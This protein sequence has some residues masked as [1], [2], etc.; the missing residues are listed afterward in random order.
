MY[1][2]RILIVTLFF[3]AS[4]WATTSVYAGANTPTSTPT[5]TPTATPT[6]V[7]TPVGN[8]AKTTPYE[9]ASLG[10]LVWLQQQVDAG[11]TF[12][13]L[14]VELTTDIDASATAGWNGGLGFNPIGTSSDTYVFRGTFLGQGYTITG[15]TIDRP[16]EDCVGLF[17]HTYSGATIKN[18]NLKDAT[19]YGKNTVGG[20]CGNAFGTTFTNCSS[21]N[22]VTVGSSNDIGGL[23]GCT[24]NGI[25]RYCSTTGT[26]RYATSSTSSLSHVG[27][28]VGYSYNEDSFQYCYSNCSIQAT[29]AKRADYVGGLVGL[30]DNASRFDYSYATGDVEGRNYVGGFAGAFNH[31]SGTG[32]SYATGNVA[33]TDYAGGFVGAMTDVSNSATKSYSL[34][35][36]TSS[37]SHVGGMVGYRANSTSKANYCYWNT[38]TSG[39]TTSDGGTSETTVRM[40]QPSTF[41]GWVFTGDTWAIDGGYPYV[42]YLT[43]NTLTYAVNNSAKGTISDGLTSD[44]TLEQVVNTGST[45]TP[46]T[47]VPNEGYTFVS[48]DDGTTETTR[49][50]A[51]VTTDTTR[52]AVF[53]PWTLTYTA[54]K[55][56]TVNGTSSVTWSIADGDDG[57][58]VTAT[59]DTGYKF[60]GWSDG[61]TA[62]PRQDASVTDDLSVTAVFGI[63]HDGDEPSGTGSSS[64]PFQI[65]T[66]YN[67]VWMQKQIDAGNYISSYFELVNDIDASE[68]AD[69]T[70]YDPT[71]DT[72]VV[73]FDPIGNISGPFYFR[74]DFSGRDH[75]ITNLTIDRPNESGV[76]LFLALGNM[77]VAGSPVVNDSGATPGSTSVSSS[78]APSETI[79]DLT[80]EGAR[81]SGLSNVG[82]IVGV[83]ASGTIINCHAIDTNLE[84]DHDDDNSKCGGVVGIAFCFDDFTMQDCSSTGVVAGNGDC[85]G[86]LIGLAY[87]DSTITD[88]YS[89]CRVVGVKKAGGL[90]GALWLGDIE[91]CYAVGPVEGT[92][93][94]GG[95]VGLLHG[96]LGN[97]CYVT[98]SY[99]VG[100]VTGTTSVGGL[101]GD[102]G[103]YF[104]VSSS[105]WNTET[106][107]LSTS[108]GGTGK[109]T[110]EMKQEATFEDWNTTDTWDIDGGY[111]YL[112]DLDTC[113]LTYE[114]RSGQGLVGDGETTE[115]ELAQVINLGST[116]TPATAVE[117]IYAFLGW[118]DGTT[119]TTRVDEGVTTDTAFLAIFNGP[120][121]TPTETSTPTPTN[122]PTPSNT[123]GSETNTPTPTKTPTATKTPTNTPTATATPSVWADS[124]D[125]VY[126]NCTGATS[127]SQLDVTITGTKASVTIKKKKTVATAGN[128][129][130]IAVS[131]DLA[132]FS[133]DGGVVDALT[134]DGALASLATKNGYVASLEAATF[135]SVKMASK[136][137]VSGATEI[138]ALGAR[139]AGAK[140]VNVALTGVKLVG[141]DAPS[142]SATIKSSSKK[143]TTGVAK[144]GVEGDVTAGDSLTIAVVGGN[145]I[146][147]I[148]ANG[149]VKNVSAKVMNVKIGATTTPYGGTVSGTI[150]GGSPSWL[151]TNPTYSGAG[152]PAIGAVFG[153]NAV[154]ETIASGYDASTSPTQTCASGLGSVGT[155]KTGTISGTAYVSSL[156]KPPVMKGD[157]DALGTTF[158]V[159][160]TP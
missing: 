141:Y 117:T 80:L 154:S 149:L 18:L 52:T 49:T 89:A 25:W 56:G 110:L 42:D 108:D 106:T 103:D 73:G 36:V 44:T 5:S 92:D 134:V 143:A 97:K 130:L 105:Y 74:G 64:D 16:S 77:T 128:I 69:W 152:K 53:A 129:P 116:G 113:T 39:L 75:V 84:S 145:V 55:H 137:G 158:I 60:F 14:Y 101:I 126:K 28:L 88:C 58:T 4:A 144:G 1:A 59:A 29:D 140:P 112:K 127:D 160:T 20:L 45:G 133:L 6:A 78:G 142:Q 155:L 67:L 121:P 72:V 12:S 93:S 33:A 61:S 119:E 30:L 24:R 147:N 47:A 57:P 41:S 151:S 65:A 107:G 40:K 96:A 132:K 102:S 32:Y 118:D 146:G 79:E 54:G 43:T 85:V 10:N 2:K 99:S 35:A 98:D 125:F 8:G 31:Y 7:P 120:T 46:V 76:G 123:P 50:D 70:D 91:N 156:A 124:Y 21:V 27:G 131:G 95:L 3:L 159:R 114:A 38:E 87:V 104:S 13:G 86:G 122:T 136:P 81:M 138:V 135:G 139:A 68:T 9:I 109:T 100:A 11:T 63:D 148:V 51:G 48:W 111:P 22:G 34:G 17:A 37:G 62:N 19:V 153:S 71:T 26:V 83:G 90:V 115:T 150:G 23:V 66:L 15:L 82:T 94:V 157:T